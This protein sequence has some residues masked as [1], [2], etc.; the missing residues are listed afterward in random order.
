MASPNIGEVVATTLR[1]R[2]KQLADNTL[3]HNALLAEINKRGKYQPVAG[4]RVITETLMYGKPN[5]L[6]LPY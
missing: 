2:R 5:V 3:N 6:T 4:G 1:H